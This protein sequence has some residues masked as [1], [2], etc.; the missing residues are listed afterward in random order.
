MPNMDAD[1]NVPR[2]ATGA[3]DKELIMHEEVPH[4]PE[5]VRATAQSEHTLREGVQDAGQTAESGAG[6]K[7]DA[8]ARQYVDQWNATEVVTALRER[9]LPVEEYQKLITKVYPLVVGFNGGLILSIGK[10]DELQRSV[11]ARE[12]VVEVLKVDHVRNSRRI[13]ALAV[14]LRNVAREERLPVL[15]ALAG[16][17]QEEQ[18]HN[19]FYRQMLEAHGIDHEAYYT[20]FEM[21][22]HALL[23]AEERDRMTQDVLTALK[24]GYTPDGFPNTDL[25]QEIL[26]LCHYL[27]RVAGDPAV[28]FITYYALQSAIEF[29]LVKAISESVFPGVAGTRDHPQLRSELVPD[30][31]V[32]VEGAVPPS[33]KWWDEH[34][35]Y[36]QGGRAELQH[37]KYGREQLNRNL[38]KEDDVAE[39]LWRVD[40]VLRLFAVI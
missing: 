26:S 6:D 37:V 1:S 34:A 11:R 24:E 10:I 7:I 8:L 40:E 20:A 2:S 3:D 17:L 14:E 23:P 12:L 16:Q 21:Y 30:A 5:T 4:P 28:P 9:R 32:T 35:D 27:V 25:P 19:D 39:V 15:R 31:E 33:I 22:L 18:E 13:Q 29:A 38:T 36:G